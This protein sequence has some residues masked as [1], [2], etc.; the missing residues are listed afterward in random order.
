MRRGVAM[1]IIMTGVI[2]MAVTT[3]ALAGLPPVP[4]PEVGVGIGAVA[5]L[6]LGYRVLKRSLRK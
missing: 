5:V 4:A 3:P 2:A 6:A 1:D